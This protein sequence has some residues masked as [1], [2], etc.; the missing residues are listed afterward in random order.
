[1]AFESLLWYSR[2]FG[3]SALP[4]RDEPSSIDSLGVVALQGRAGDIYTEQAFRHFLDVERVR[5]VRSGRTFFLLLVSLRRCPEQ[6]TRFGSGAAASLLQGLGG[7]VREIDF[8]GWH[9]DG[10]VAGAVLAQGLDEPGPDAAKRIVERVTRVLSDHL[11]ASVASRLRVRV[12]QLGSQS[13]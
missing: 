1:M 13:K 11:T 3:Q 8:I 10:R 6:G 2:L 7:C 4:K 9:R 12:V 5:A